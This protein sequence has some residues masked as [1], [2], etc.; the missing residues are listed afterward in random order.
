VRTTRILGKR[1][2]IL[3]DRGSGNVN[4]H[5]YKT[6]GCNIILWTYY[7]CTEY[8]SVRVHNKLKGVCRKLSQLS[9]ANCSRVTDECIICL[10]GVFHCVY[11]TFSLDNTSKEMLNT[12]ATEL[13]GWLRNANVLSDARIPP[14]I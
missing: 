5:S 6:S 4:N 13:Y 8:T 12:V 3:L 7:E 1:D 9:I 14:A 11:F 10:W 2:V